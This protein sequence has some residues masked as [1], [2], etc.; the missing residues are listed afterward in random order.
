MII[1]DPQNNIPQNSIP[2][3]NIPQ[4]SIPY[5]NIPYN[6]IPY[7]NIPYNIQQNNFYSSAYNKIPYHNTLK[8][9]N[10][11]KNI[12]PPPYHTDSLTLVLQKIFPNDYQKYLDLF[13]TQQIDY[14]AFLLLDKDILKELGILFGPIIKICKAI[15][16]IN[17]GNLY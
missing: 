15:E 7:N 6:N 9:I 10:P 2:Y 11:Y 12:D 5:N 16:N 1:H 3:N 8:I 14:D 4:N 13:K 17:Q